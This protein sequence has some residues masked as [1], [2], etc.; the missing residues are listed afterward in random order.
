LPGG[1]NGYAALNTAATNYTLFTRGSML[2]KWEVDD[3]PIVFN[4]DTGGVVFNNVGISY[5]TTP[6]TG[7][8]SIVC[9]GGGGA[10][11]AGQSTPSISAY[12]SGGGGALAYKNNISVAYGETFI[13]NV[14]HGGVGGRRATNPIGSDGGDSYV[15]RSDGTVICRAGGGK[16][17]G[18][19]FGGAG[20]TVI[21]GDNTPGTGLGG[22][23]A[24][25]TSQGATG[26]GA[27][28]YSGN[29]G[30]GVTG[31]NGNAGT[32]GGGGS[33]GKNTSATNSSGGGGGGVG[34][35]GEG[36]SGIRGQSSGTGGGGGSGGVGGA[37]SA[38][39]LG[40]NTGGAGGWY[41]GGGG[42]PDDTGTLSSVGGN[43]GQGG[44][45]IVWKSS[46]NPV[47]RAFPSTNVSS[48]VI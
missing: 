31:D 6:V 24:F 29:G 26:A 11:S 47:I 43:G 16:A 40:S 9:V 1:S 20:G 39:G 30:N 17:G 45:R 8:I 13:I 48:N 15:S 41:G 5:W 27:G 4:T 10:G 44:V 22:N 34:L 38:G 25:N 19:S 46:A 23:G 12:G 18:T 42:S 21:I 35:F 14:G 33:G 36:T 28:G 32:G 3:E 7:T 2:L 37:V